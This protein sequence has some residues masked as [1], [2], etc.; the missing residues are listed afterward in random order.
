MTSASLHSGRTAAARKETGP[1]RRPSADLKRLA[2][3]ASGG[4]RQE[5]G[6]FFA[7]FCG[8]LLMLGG[9]T[10][11]W[12]EPPPP[13]LAAPERVSA[14][15]A[16]AAAAMA[17]ERARRREALARAELERKAAEEAAERARRTALLADAAAEAEARRQREELANNQAA[18]AKARRVTEESEDA[19]K[20]FY[21]PSERCRTPEGAASVECANEYV[22]ARRAFGARTAGG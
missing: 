8:L 5:I 18:A 14:E 17:V 20:R 9:A 19:W 3:P 6:P 1:E 4:L 2:L 16:E 13:S 7:L 15:A 10:I 21:R 11:Y 12:L 22:K